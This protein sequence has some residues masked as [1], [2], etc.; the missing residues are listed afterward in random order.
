MTYPE[1]IEY[2]HG[3]RVFG[4]QFGLETMRDLA[5]RL[6]NPQNSLRFLHIAGTNGKGSVAAMCAAVLRAAGYRTGLYTSP[7]LVSFCERFQVNGT[8]IVPADVVRLVE[9]IAPLRL[10]CAREPTYFETVTAIALEYFRE[11]Q[12]DIVVWE[13][14]LGGRLDATNIVTPAVAVITSIGFDHMQYLGDT[15]AKIAFEK[16]G[17]IKTGIPTVTVRQE[18]AAMQVIREVARDCGSLLTEVDTPVSFEPPLAGAH[19]RWNCAVAHAALRAGGFVFTEE[20]WQTGLAQTVWPGR[21]Q[22]IGD[23][24]L[25]G[26]HNPAGAAV[27]AATLRERFPGRPVLL[28]IGVLKDKDYRH[29]CETLAP[30]AR[31]VVCVPVRNERTLPPT[32]LVKQFPAAMIAADVREAL[33]KC[34]PGELAVVTGSLFLVGEALQVL[35]PGGVSDREM[36]LQ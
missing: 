1:A 31:R 9:R 36:T 27:L 11:Q 16:A 14:G 29:V 19:Q 4:M 21:F 35:R 8:P 25:D 6:G 3:I 33:A 10:A 15:L 28:I 2:L 18:P 24:V 30:A 12:V 26:A 13:T 5:G 7:H 34:Q 17:I 20:Q 32:E 23:V 22:V